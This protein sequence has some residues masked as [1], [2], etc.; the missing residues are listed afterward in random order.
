MHHLRVTEK[1][2]DELFARS[3]CFVHANMEGGIQERA[4]EHAIPVTHFEFQ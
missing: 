1:G 2:Q 3:V 4:P